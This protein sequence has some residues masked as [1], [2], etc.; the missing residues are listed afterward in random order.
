MEVHLGLVT[1]VVG[2]LVFDVIAHE[3]LLIVFEL[4]EFVHVAYDLAEMGRYKSVGLG[5]LRAVCFRRSVPAGIR[6]RGC[7][8]HV[9]GT[10]TIF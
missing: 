1:V 9:P 5:M 4:L 7:I 10:D 8:D 3:G 2:P 6:T